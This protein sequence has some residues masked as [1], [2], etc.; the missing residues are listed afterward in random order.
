MLRQVEERLYR[1]F[2][3]MPLGKPP[4]S[5]WL[6]LVVLDGLPCIR[7]QVRGE[8]AK[9]PGRWREEVQD[10][11]G[12]GVR[13]E[14]CPFSGAGKAEPRGVVVMWQALMKRRL[15]VHPVGLSHGDMAAPFTGCASSWWW[16]W[17]PNTRTRRQ[18][19]AA[20]GCRGPGGCHHLVSAVFHQGQLHLDLTERGQQVDDQSPHLR[21]GY[22][23]ATAENQGGRRQSTTVSFPCQRGQ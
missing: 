21:C 6:A 18:K 20:A 16:D 15:A 8:A 4:T 13:T 2:P 14:L 19:P 12:G 3:Y 5:G 7:L 23:R 9:R 11:S 22:C 1:G 17:S 10:E